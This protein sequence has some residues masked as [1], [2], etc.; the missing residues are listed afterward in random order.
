MSGDFVA[1]FREAFQ[2]A[3]DAGVDDLAMGEANWALLWD[4]AVRKAASDLMRPDCDPVPT[5][6]GNGAPTPSPSVDDSNAWH[7][8]IAGES[9]IRCVCS[10]C[11]SPGC[12]VSGRPAR[13]GTGDRGQRPGP[14]EPASR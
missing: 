11:L 8:G 14:G 1:E 7:S 2:A 5:Q 13:S 9:A 6:G 10:V 3:C 12:P 4:V